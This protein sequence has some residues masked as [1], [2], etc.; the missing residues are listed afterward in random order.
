M[1]LSYVGNSAICLCW[2]TMSKMWNT[3]GHSHTR[4]SPW[5]QY[6]TY[7][8]IIM[9]TH[10]AKDRLVTFSILLWNY[11]SQLQPQIEHYG[12]PVSPF[13]PSQQPLKG[14]V[15]GCSAMAGTVSCVCRSLHTDKNTY[16]TEVSHSYSLL[17]VHKTWILET[18]LPVK[19]DVYRPSKP[20]VESYI[21]TAAYLHLSI[22]TITAGRKTA[23][24]SCVKYAANISS[25]LHL[26][27]TVLE[28][29]FWRELRVHTGRIVSRW[30][31]NRGGYVGGHQYH[32]LLCTAT[33]VVYSL[34]NN[35]KIHT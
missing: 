10:R 1:S 35:A 9:D 26:I 16:I 28:L 21:L 24:L 27:L 7:G 15:M 34:S 8:L 29:Q 11:C 14:S 31:S 19:G 17:M 25:P 33:G 18:S 3:V 30:S 6:G 13:N 2:E 22:N 23:A 32:T 5:V 12:V 4:T 20:T